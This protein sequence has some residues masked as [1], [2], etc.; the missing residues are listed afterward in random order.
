[1]G[2]PFERLVDASHRSSPAA[3]IA[4]LSPSAL[5]GVSAS[6]ATH[7]Q[8]AFGI[9]TVRELATSPVVAAARA[10]LHGAG[11]PGFDP[12]PPYPWAARF[13]AAPLDHY[14]NHPSGRFRLAFGPVYYR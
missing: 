1:M 11:E 13:A 4:G 5:L 3:T 7:L 12:G 14:L 6:D 8:D 10:V 2:S 9:D